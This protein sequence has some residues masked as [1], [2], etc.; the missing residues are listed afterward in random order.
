MAEPYLS[1]IRMFGGNFAPRSWAFCSGALVS[2]SQNT[3]LFS[4]V[5]TTYGG[6]GRVS[7]GLPDFR[8]RLPIGQGTGP[9]LTS[10][11]IG[12]R[13]GSESLTLA[14]ENLPAHTHITNAAQGEANLNIPENGSLPAT[15]A[16]GGLL[17]SSQKPG[18]STLDPNTL[19]DAGGTAPHDNMMPSL[20]V[21]FIIAMFG[22]YPSRN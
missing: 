17:Y 7:F 4:L 10:R 2:I 20:A 21:S 11:T 1:E 18:N 12:Q 16:N 8:G 9:G 6:D 14:Q 19:A 13:L 15:V 5:G 22:T 3:A